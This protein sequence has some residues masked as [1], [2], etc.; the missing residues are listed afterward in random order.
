MW[1]IKDKA[2]SW[3]CVFPFSTTN[4][5]RISVHSDHLNKYPVKVTVDIHYAR[6]GQCPAL[7]LLN[8]GL[9]LIGNRSELHPIASNDHYLHSRQDTKTLVHTNISP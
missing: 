3:V 8:T 9:G 6:Q 2:I 5:I 1:I 7:V 4:P